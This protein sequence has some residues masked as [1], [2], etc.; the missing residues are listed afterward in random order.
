MTALHD[1]QQVLLGVVFFFAVLIVIMAFAGLVFVFLCD[2]D[3]E[4]DQ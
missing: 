1:L 4:D 3:N 2:R